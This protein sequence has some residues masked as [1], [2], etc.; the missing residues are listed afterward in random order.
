MGTTTSSVGLRL[1]QVFQE[2]Y[3]QQQQQQQQQ[4]AFQQ[5]PQQQQQQQ[6]HSY[7][8]YQE[9]TDGTAALPLLP[10]L[11]VD[12]RIEPHITLINPAHVGKF[13]EEMPNLPVATI[14]NN[15]VL[16][17]LNFLLTFAAYLNTE[18]GKQR[19][20]LSHGFHPDYPSLPKP[21]A[22]PKS[23]S[24]KPRGRPRKFPRSEDA[25]D[26]PRP[27]DFPLAADHI[28]RLLE[29]QY[30]YQHY[31]QPQLQPHHPQQQLL[32]AQQEP[33][34]WSPLG[35]P[36]P[37]PTTAAPTTPSAYNYNRQL[38]PAPSAY[39]QSQ[40]QPPSSSG[41]LQ[42]LLPS[43]DFLPFDSG[44]FNT[45]YSA[46][47][48]FLGLYTEMDQ[49]LVQG[50]IF[51]DGTSLASEF[52][53]VETGSSSTTTT[54]TTSISTLDA[55]LDVAGDSASTSTTGTEHGSDHASTAHPP[56]DGNL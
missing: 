9:P 53:A 49:V 36:T 28:P 27:P 29:Q 23:V 50:A 3:Q 39:W 20:G 14:L 37:S 43:S 32:P 47:D 55:S 41:Q 30:Q 54:T 15:Q 34:S 51:G 18:R 25:N 12:G 40:A 1:Q 38:V 45:E 42:P 17:P 19:R 6:Q 35:A 44:L 24:N 2:N 4:Q 46:E 13:A 48:D 16:V 8:P 22:P 31:Q 7:Q 21:E 33:T 26:P 11:P 10:M 5:Q 56:T 52:G